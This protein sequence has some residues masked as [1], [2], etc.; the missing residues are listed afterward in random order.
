MIATSD[1]TVYAFR[2]NL[3]VTASAGT[4]KTFRLVTLYA[5]LTLGLTS[6]GC[7][8]DATPS[9][10]ISPS[11]IAATTFSRAAAAEIR[12]RI[13][14]LLRAVAAASY[15]A[16][17]EPYRVILDERATRT[18]SPAVD[19]RVMR[20]RAAAALR[21][22]PHA[23]IDTLHGL[24]GRIVRGSAL[25]LG[26]TPA[27]GILD[28]D[29]ARASVD[30]AVEEGLSAALA[31]GDRGAMDL[32]D[33]GGGL[34]M[35][36]R[37]I[38][39]LL[40][41]A[42]EEGVD[43]TSLVCT[44][45]VGAARATLLRLRDIAQ[46]LIADGSKA[47]AEPAH[48]ALRTARAF[49]DGG[50]SIEDMFRGFEP[51]FS[52]RA[53]QRLPSE[54]AFVSFRNSIRGEKNADKALSLAA[55]AASAHEIGPRTRQMAAV[56]A[57][58]ARR[59]AT[60]RRNAGV[61]GFG[62]LLRVAR[63]TVRD[64]LDVA[65]RA[66]AARD[67]LLVDEFQDTS[68]VQRDLVYLLRESESS[69][70]RR[71]AGALPTA[72]DLDPAGLLVVGDRKQSIYGFRGADVTVFAEVAADLAGASAVTA[73]DLPRDRP[74]GASA[75]AALVSLAENRRSDPSILQFVNWF[76]SADFAAGGA[77]PFDIR[78]AESEHL[79]P[80]ETPVSRRAIEGPRVLLVDDRDE[81]PEDAPAIVRGSKGSMRDA[82]VAAGAIDHVLRAGGCKTF[83]FRDVAVLARR[84]ATLPLL[85]FALARLDIPYV[86][87]GRGLFETREVRDIAALLRLILD[88][89][90]RHALATVLRGP[91]LALTDTSL[92]FL[93]EPGKGLVPPS[94]WFFPD[95]GAAARLDPSERE[96]LRLF[97]QRFADVRDVCLGL[98]PAD[99][100]RHAVEQIELDR[101]IAALPH[102]SQHL[103]NIDRLLALASQQGGSL[104]GF[105]RWLERQIDDQT[106]ESEAA[107]LSEA[108]DAVT[109]MTI[110]ASK[111]LEFPVVVLVDAGAAVRAQPLTMAIASSGDAGPRLVVRHTR[112]V[113]GTLYTPEATEHHREATAREVAERRRLTYV[114]M[115]RAREKL[116]VVVPAAEP[117]G[118]A[119]STL[120]KLLA[121][122]EASCPGTRVEPAAQFLVERTGSGSTT[123]LPSRAP[124]GTTGS[125]IRRSLPVLPENAGVLSLSTTPFATFAE[126]PRK[127]R[128]VNEMGL[129][130]PL[131]EGARRLLR[132]SPVA[133][134]RAAGTAA[135]R[136]LELYPL[137]R[138]GE[139]VDR[140]EIER[141]LVRE[142]PIETAT[143]RETTSAN[144]A[145]F[146]ASPYAAH[147]RRSGASVYREEPFVLDLGKGHDRLHLRGTVDLL[148]A[149]PDGSADV[150]DYKSSGSQGPA[151]DFQLRAYGLAARR[152]YDVSPV[153]AA[154][155]DLSSPDE[156]APRELD[157][158]DHARFESR[159][160]DLR[161]AFVAARSH[162]HFG[163]LDR[164][165]CEALRCGFIRACHG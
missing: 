124:E 22:I 66:R 33:A 75:N 157:E 122:A 32:L 129:E 103:G 94:G 132:A 13:E 120:R 16:Q 35:T 76:A 100:I 156:P 72:S 88:P 71:K 2:T 90:D 86:V 49:L 78:Y 96:R 102:A 85:E 9:P 55:F 108:D 18:R 126:C 62:D 41:R 145:R 10:P 95:G 23:L 53:Q 143:V 140:S 70:S 161:A 67:V 47:L 150:I 36:R 98:G 149:F 21:E 91:A 59:R 56:L 44:D 104:A 148:V 7:A 84:R 109:L 118:S 26:L 151:R 154:I 128:L 93:S 15:D 82:F 51:L 63:D 116:I 158:A 160:L 3:V 133:E 28:E 131:W 92:A 34:G 6:I 107:V 57:D 14:R 83:S 153:R 50:A 110:H 17:T 58:I 43:V 87:A 130:V 144:V 5:L 115:T 48:D 121:D 8:D 74:A 54:E 111:G 152:R 27:F 29:Q 165:E 142:M 73:L 123:E 20:D 77:H 81:T 40:D 147:V 25:E 141:L 101:V 139:T 24:A 64:R 4:G 80:A 79:V 162:A 134:V 97:A 117:P 163:G 31:R 99:A 42:D 61:L 69:R 113:G 146:L 119:A 60:A 68:R 39:D 1:E 19:A 37:R 112:D 45:M 136:V 30:A 137:D 125:V 114:A 46:A 164:V 11:R 12:E 159:L 155:V 89:Y 138:W 38:A 65:A 52:K 127:Y 105:V 106:D 135:H